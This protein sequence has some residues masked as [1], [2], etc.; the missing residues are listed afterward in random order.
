M[1]FN[2]NKKSVKNFAA[3]FLQII[4]MFPLFSLSQNIPNRPT[5][6]INVNEG[7]QTSNQIWIHPKTNELGVLRIGPFVNISKKKILTIDTT[8]C[9]TSNDNGSTWTAYPIFKNPKNFIIRVE[10]ALIKTKKGTIILAFTNDAER[11]PL[12]WKDD[13]HDAA[14]TILPTYTVRSEDNGKTWSEPIKLHDD[15][16]GAVRDIIETKD[17]HVVFTTM[18]M[19]HNPGHHTVL[20]YTSADEGKSWKQSNVI[21]LG[22]IGHHSGVTE[23]TLEEVKDGKLLMYMRTNWGSLWE[24]TS[25]DN[26]LTWTNF[27]STSIKASSAPALLTRLQSGRLMLLWNHNLPQGKNTFPMSGG[28]NNWSEVPVSNH[29]QELSIMFSEDEG[30]NWSIP[31]VIA[32]TTKP[33]SQLTYPYVLEKNPGEIWITT[34][35]GELRMTLLESDFIK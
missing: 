21:D 3:F 13:I 14:N 16:T 33:K 2:F 35:F 19:R 32:K 24:T 11:S 27:K 10:R 8:N 6:T 9:Y 17:G 18:M 12:L 31:T 4:M 30:M 22:G 15:W 1:K 25:S 29:R 23:S 28:D 34:M 26:G 20:T 5:D 7:Q